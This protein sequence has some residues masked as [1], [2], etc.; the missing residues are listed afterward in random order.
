MYKT[1][2]VSWLLKR[3]TC[4]FVVMILVII[5]QFTSIV[6]AQSSDDLTKHEWKI[7]DVVGKY[8]NS[9]PHRPDQVFI[10]KY[11]TSNGTIDAFGA[12][13][14]SFKTMV[15]SNGS[16]TFYIQIPR[17]YPYT[18]VL[19]EGKGTNSFIV[20]VNGTEISQFKST[21][22]NCFFVF[23]IPFHGNSIIEL[24]TTSIME[25]YPFHGDKIPDSC[26]KETIFQSSTNNTNETI[27]EFTF[28]IPVFIISI[29]SLIIFYR[30]KFK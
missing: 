29:A 15:N 7:Y 19:G 6:Y 10:I 26:I 3:I 16:G 8:L 14:N 28:A 17:N 22:T 4:S 24:D 12:E 30:I 2:Y 13:Q 21:I 23:S 20:L 18:D 1:M 5:M 25:N 27:P 9:D 11:R